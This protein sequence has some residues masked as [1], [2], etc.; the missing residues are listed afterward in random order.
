MGMSCPPL[1]CVEPHPTHQGKPSWNWKIILRDY[2]QIIG[3]KKWNNCNL[4]H[5][6]CSHYGYG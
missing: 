2:C 4:D 6:Y 3:V 1:A 5:Q